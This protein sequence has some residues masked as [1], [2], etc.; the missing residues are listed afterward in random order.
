MFEIDTEGWLATVPHV[1]SPNQDERPAG[2]DI[3]LLVVHGISLPPGEYGGD[4]ITDL[5][6]NRLD[7]SA[8]PYFEEIAGMEVSAHALIRRDGEVLQYVPFSRR[9]WHAGR[10]SFEGVS[11]CN[12]YAIGIELEGCDSDGYT[13]IQ[14]QKL[15][16]LSAAL[17]AHYP[18]LTAERIVGHCDIAPGRKTDP[19]EAFDWP[20]FRS[21]VSEYR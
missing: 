20:L 13:D 2:V 7:S 15:A 8:H 5:F 11:A 3:S 19:G 21:K 18:C 1:P 6:M 9:A 12:D 14:Y 16:A 10:S 17:V 4:W